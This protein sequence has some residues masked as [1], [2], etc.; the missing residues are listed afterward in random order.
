MSGF[1]S[2]GG[3]SCDDPDMFKMLMIVE[4]GSKERTL[5]AAIT[6]GFLFIN[7]LGEKMGV[8]LFFWQYT[9]GNTI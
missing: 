5:V 1:F 8:C 7:N 3:L 9:I 4:A 6:L 2:A